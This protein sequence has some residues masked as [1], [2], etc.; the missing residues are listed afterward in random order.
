MCLAWDLGMMKAMMV[1]VGED[2]DLMKQ[3]LWL[4]VFASAR[5]KTGSSSF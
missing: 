4:T 1:V 3:A 5:K 2:D